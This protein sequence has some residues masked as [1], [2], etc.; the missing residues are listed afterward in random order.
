LPPQLA[1]AP[2]DGVAGAA[3]AGVA[4]AGESAGF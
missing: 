4:L 1:C 2:P 3:V